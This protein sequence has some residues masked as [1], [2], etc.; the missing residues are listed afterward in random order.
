MNFNIKVD[1][2]DKM[3]RHEILLE[4][5]NRVSDVFSIDMLMFGNTPDQLCN[6]IK[7]LLSRGIASAEAHKL[8]LLENK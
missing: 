7:E 5:P 2:N 6:L 1:Y 3:N 4:G 8:H